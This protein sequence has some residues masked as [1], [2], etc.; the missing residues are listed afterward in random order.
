MGWDEEDME[1]TYYLASLDLKTGTVEK[2]LLLEGDDLSYAT[3]IGSTVW[4]WNTVENQQVGVGYDC[5][6]NEVAHATLPQDSYPSFSQDG[7][8]YYSSTDQRLM[9]YTNASTEEPDAVSFNHNFGVQYLS[10]LFSSEEGTQYAVV[11]GR[12]GDLR[13]YCAVVNVD[14]GE[15]CYAASS[16]TSD[17]YLYVENNALVYQETHYGDDEPADQPEMHYVIYAGT[18]PYSYDW[19]GDGYLTVSVLEGGRLLF[20]ETEYPEEDGDEIEINLWLYDGKNGSLL[21]STTIGQEDYYLWVCSYTAFYPTDEA[22]LLAVG[23]SQEQCVSYYRWDYGQSAGAELSLQVQAADISG[24]LLV[25]LSDT[26]D[27]LSF[28][29]SPCPEELADLRQRA[30]ELQ[31]ELGIKIYISTECS[32]ILGGYA[33]ED[34]SDRDSIASALDALE[35]E[36]GKYPEGFLG[37]LKWS[38]VDGID[39]YIAGSLIG[40][41]SDILTYAGGFTTTENNRIL[42]AMDCTSS[43]SVG[44]TLHHELSHAIDNKLQSDY[45]H[46]YLND[47]EW[48]LM[49]TIPNY[50]DDCYTY[51]YTQFGKDELLSYTLEHGAMSD[52]YFVDGYAMTFP[53]EDRA[54]LFENVMRDDQWVD[55]ENCPHLREKL[56]YY[57]QCIRACFDTTG[58]EDVPWEQ[59]LDEDALAD[60]G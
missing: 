19:Y 26:W 22:L 1:A 10:G 17:Q 7:Q 18:Q 48:D 47:E 9:R 51:T 28:I 34:L 25:N 54:R 5:Y 4:W 37:Q 55:W 24:D 31:E 27:P 58:W 30:D 50:Y 2:T 40:T 43:W 46:N 57:A 44:T 6:L 32:N 42:I 56:N 38:W 52:A 60:A 33:I 53:T 41:S 21:G 35:Y 16:D 45:D 36:A 12:G 15:V 20:Q 39:L 59:Y 3:Q 14:T 23:S 29:P 8:Y 11:S 49:N 13:N